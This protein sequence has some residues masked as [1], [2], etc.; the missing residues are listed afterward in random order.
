L[1]KASYQTKHLIQTIFGDFLQKLLQKL[2]IEEPILIGHSN[3]GRIIINSVGR[4]IVKPKKIILIDSAGIKPRRS[5]KYY[6]K[7]YTFKL[8]KKIVK[9]LPNSKE[10]QEKLIKK[11][12]S[13]DYQNSPEVLRR[14]MSIIIN[15][16]QTENIKKINVPTLLI[17]GEK[18]TAT[19]IEDAKKMEKLIPDSGI[20][21]YPGSGHFS[22]LEN[23][24]SVQIVL[25]EFLK[26]E[27]R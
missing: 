2:E 20:V 6:I 3:G 18:D 9:L 5:I 7:I 15:E 14:T 24:A 23:L 25:Q 8:S 16:D 26:K 21:S 4:G 19:P 27:A 22:Y 13:Q 12:S 17:W 11:H 1:E 10:L